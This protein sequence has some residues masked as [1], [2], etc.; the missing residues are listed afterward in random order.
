[1]VSIWKISIRTHLLGLTLYWLWYSRRQE[2][3]GARDPY[4]GFQK[5]LCRVRA[6]IGS[7]IC[8]RSLG[9][10]HFVIYFTI[11]IYSNLFLIIFGKKH[12]KGKCKIEHFSLFYKLIFV[13]NLESG[14]ISS[15]YGASA[16]SANIDSNKILSGW[17]PHHGAVEPYGWTKQYA[18]MESRW[19]CHGVSGYYISLQYSTTIHLSCPSPLHL[20]PSVSIVLPSAI[21]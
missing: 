5:F 17:R 18:H 6:G 19:Y 4:Y 8:P 11:Q 15:L 2:D 16:G 13:T 9:S 21:T 14:L 7:T 10:F 3:R 20:L 12:T 1:M